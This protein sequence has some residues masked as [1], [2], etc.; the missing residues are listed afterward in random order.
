MP[1]ASSTWHEAMPDEPAPMMQTLAKVEASLPMPG[2]LASLA[3]LPERERVRADARRQLQRQ[4]PV[5]H[6]RQRDEPVEALRAH[7]QP[8]AVTSSPASR[9]A[10]GWPSSSTCAVRAAPVGR[11]QHEEHPAGGRS[12]R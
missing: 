10:T 1:R 5:L 8:A 2:W 6:A 4:P 9:A 7:R 12:A 3:G 11:A